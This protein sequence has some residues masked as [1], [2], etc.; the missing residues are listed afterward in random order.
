MTFTELVK[1]YIKNNK[2]I[3]T[4]YVSVCCLVYMV[5]V[6]LTSFAYSRMFDEKEK[7]ANVIKEI[8]MVWILLCI[9]YVLKLR[10]ETILIPDFLSFIRKKLFSNYIKNNEH[11]FNDTDVSS[12]LNKIIEVTRNIRDVFQWIFGTF[13]P[14][15]ILM[16]TINAFFLYKYPKIGMVMMI[17]NTVNYNIIKSFAPSLI[18]SANIREDE[19]LKML[20]KLDENFNNLMNIF[21]N[22]KSDATIKENEEIEA[23][24]TNIYRNQNKELESFGTKLKANNYMFAFISLW[25]LYKSSPSHKDFINGLLVFTFYL[26]TLE[27]MAEDIP[28]SIMTLGNIENIEDSLKAKDPNHIMIQ[29]IYA[30]END[31]KKGLTSLKGDIEF[32]N[33]YFRY[34]EKRPYVLDNFSLKIPAGDKVAIVSQSGFGKSTSMKLLLG[35]Y[36]QEKG[37]IL[38]DGVPLSDYKINDVRARINYI[39]QRTL[40]FNATVMNNLKYGNTKTDEQILSLLKKYDLL[41]ILCK[42]NV[43]CLDKIVDKNG[44]NISMG[45]Q[46]VIFLVRGI[47]KNNVSV[48]IFDEP[49]T[50]IDPSTRGQVLDMIKNETE[51]KTVIIITHD[52]EV[53]KI[54]NRTVEL[55]KKE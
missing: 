28:F 48:Y 17:G 53:N 41:K 46:K 30:H 40:L 38:L 21:L 33:I 9:L 49:L 27:N 37:Q 2:R 7:F 23:Q 54:V 50:S 34:D 15:V 52:K 11:R 12:D 6:L 8:C 19:F 32:K 43:N 55:T 13:V 44:T 14:T 4:A 22:D 10:V 25:I 42:D 20:G 36:R 29:P 35:F 1:D 39:N 26:S 5:K 3:F 31:K 47:L 24:Y 51:G 45:M 16:G 18:H